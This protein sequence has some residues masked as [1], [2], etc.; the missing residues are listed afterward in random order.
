VAQLQTCY[1]NQ[2]FLNF[3]LQGEEGYSI[4]VAPILLVGTGKLFQVETEKENG[5]V[6]R[7]RYEADAR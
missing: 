3:R 1:H 7:L 6:R 4:P 2:T 5:R